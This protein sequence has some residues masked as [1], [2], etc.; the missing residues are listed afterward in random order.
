MGCL[1]GWRCL[2]N[3]LHLGKADAFDFSGLCPS[4]LA[5]TDVLETLN[6]VLLLTF[7]YFSYPVWQTH[8]FFFHLV[9]FS[10]DTVRGSAPQ[11]QSLF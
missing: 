1:R 5:H 6:L 9:R 3:R 7:I 2:N 4:L 8:R 11:G 10:E